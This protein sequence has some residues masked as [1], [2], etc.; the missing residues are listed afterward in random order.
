VLCT[1]L[2]YIADADPTLIARLR[3]RVLPSGYRAAIGDAL[4]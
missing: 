4:R 2:S 1:A 3:D